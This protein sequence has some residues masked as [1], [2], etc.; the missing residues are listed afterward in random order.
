M[1]RRL[2]IEADGGSRGNPG[3]AG[4]GAVVMD[5]DTGEVLAERAA[6]LG[7]VTNNVAEYRGLIA[8]LTTVVE[9]SRLYDVAAVAVQMDSKLVVEQ[10]SGRWKV[11]HPDMIP[12][13]REAA[14]LLRS[15]PGS[16][17]FQWIPRE[18]N[19]HADRLANE[20]MD[21][22][23]AGRAWEGG[24]EASLPVAIP[25]AP[26]APSPGWSAAGTT[27]TTS[28]LLRHGQTP[29]SVEKRF[30]GHGDP[31]LTALGRKQAADAAAR[32]AREF[33][34]APPA[35]IVS[36][37]LARSRQTAAAVVELLGGSVSIDDRLI[38]TDFGEWEGLTFAEVSARAPD[39][40][41]AWLASPDVAPPGGESFTAVAARVAEVRDD[42]LVSYPGRVVLAVSHVS[43][44][45]SFVR[46]ALEAGP[47]VLY[48]THLDLCGITTIDWYSDGPASLRGWN[49]L[50]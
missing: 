24:T 28:V 3:P 9:L 14:E 37:P 6:G 17:R 44:I 50:T 47:S 39:E 4:Y 13:A 46:L 16:V 41:S 21:A 1:S 35:V 19:K 49:A 18:R 11:K 26:A 38:E 12:L 10:M 27:A 33:A 48:R 34:D 42:W 8:G 25:L 32:L 22:Q 43:P 2:L 40:L 31:A 15:L 29:L 36:S 7:K 45:K 5:H 20:A 23:A 30:S